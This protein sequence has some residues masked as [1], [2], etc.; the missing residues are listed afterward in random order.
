MICAGTV[1]L[2]LFGIVRSILTV[3]RAMSPSMLA[4]TDSLASV[5]PDA[6]ISWIAARTRSVPSF[7]AIHAVT[8]AAPLPYVVASAAMRRIE[9]PIVSSARSRARRSK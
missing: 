2:Q 9:S 3:V 1:I 4:A 8:A 7:E 5:S 6:A